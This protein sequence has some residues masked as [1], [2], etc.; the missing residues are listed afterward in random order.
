VVITTKGRSVETRVREEL[1]AKYGPGHISKFGIITPDSGDEFKVRNLEWFLPG[2]H[3]YYQVLNPDDDGR[4]TIN[5]PGFVRIETESAYQRRT[6]EE[7]KAP[8]SVL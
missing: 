7:K 6:A 2:L 3:V 4:V 5:G 1:I 8:K